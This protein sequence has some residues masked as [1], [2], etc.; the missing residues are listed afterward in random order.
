M[1]E[2]LKAA[3]SIRGAHST[4]VGIF[5]NVFQVKF[6]ATLP[7]LHDLQG[8]TEIND[9]TTDRVK[10]SDNAEKQSEFPAV[11]I[12][13]KNQ[14]MKSATNEMMEEVITTLFDGQGNTHHGR[15]TH[16]FRSYLL[17]NFIKQFL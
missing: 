6:T 3:E 13:N 4:R 5:C 8:Y 2:L 10:R 11:I 14:L 16:I 1:D 15:I 17:I 7:R 12:C 9:S